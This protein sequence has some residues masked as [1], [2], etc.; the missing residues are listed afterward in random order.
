MDVDISKKA[1]VAF[2][3]IRSKDPGLPFLLQR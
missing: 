2:F 3:G 1:G